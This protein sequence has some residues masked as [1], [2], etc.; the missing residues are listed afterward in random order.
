M[1]WPGDWYRQMAELY[2]DQVK[3]GET[4]VQPLGKRGVGPG[5]VRSARNSHWCSVMLGELAGV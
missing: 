4:K 1:P 2:R 5:G 3:G